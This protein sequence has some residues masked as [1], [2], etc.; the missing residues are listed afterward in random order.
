[1]VV[2]LA[3]SLPDQYG[4]H[5][6]QQAV[7]VVQEDLKGCAKYVAQCEALAPLYKR[8]ANG[9]ETPRIGTY[10]QRIEQ[11][12]K[13]V[14]LVEKALRATL[15]DY[16]LLEDQLEALCKEKGEAG[17]TVSSADV[18]NLPA[19]DRLVKLAQELKVL[20]AQIES[21]DDDLWIDWDLGDYLGSDT[22][23]YLRIQEE[24]PGP[25][26]D[27][28]IEPEGGPYG[29]LSFYSDPEYIEDRVAEYSPGEG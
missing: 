19:F 10:A 22:T 9:L 28:V 15:P 1:M 12:A 7:G 5:D 29:A 20:N 6:A 13:N 25:F 3:L 18:E 8:L 23:V 16:P 11:R 17:Q 14:Q 4:S 2:R 24:N 27:S 21:E 26:I